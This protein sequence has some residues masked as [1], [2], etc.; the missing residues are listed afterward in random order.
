MDAIDWSS[1]NDNCAGDE[2]LVQ[3]VL[4]LFAREEPA[5]REGVRL[6]VVAKDAHALKRSAHRL[7][8]ALVSL[9]APGSVSLAQELEACG[10]AGR[11]QGVDQVFAALEAELDRVRQALSGRG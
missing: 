4:E 3:E 8:G 2:G 5:L 6:A 11:V 10:A 1:L 7:K 9:A